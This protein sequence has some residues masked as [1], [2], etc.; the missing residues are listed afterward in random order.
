[1]VQSHFKKVAFILFSLAILGMLI[2]YVPE[3]ASADA[4]EEN[5]VEKV[6]HRGAAG[7][8][9]ENTMAAF[10]K[11]VEMDSDYIELDVQMS[12]DGELVV[13]HDITVDRTTDG[14]GRVG[15]LTYDEL[16]KL[17]AGSWYGEAFKGEHLPTLGEVLDAYEGDM[18]F[19]I[20]LKSPSLYPGIEEKVNDALEKRDLD[21][22][23]EESVIVQSFDFHS[24]QMFHKINDEVP[25]GVLTS[26]PKDLTAQ[27]L[28]IF[29]EYADYVNPSKDEV[30][31]DLVNQI[32]ELDM[33]IMPW[34]VRAKED[35]Q[36]LLD[37]GVD[38]IITDYPDYIPE[39]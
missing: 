23:E 32:H 6:A 14:S 8:A 5:D 4:E 29:K 7:Y 13:I 28:E 38:G 36:P 19:L 37:A 1:M 24:M 9:P 17:D 21:E 20:E 3:K 34:T 10:D 11:A 39:D 25:I 27:S 31:R 2:G 35:V 16:R 30:D 15:D 12:K 26:N 33:G 18:K 22:A